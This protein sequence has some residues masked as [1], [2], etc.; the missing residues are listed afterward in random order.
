MRGVAIFYGQ[1]HFEFHWT[2]KYQAFRRRLEWLATYWKLE[3][4]SFLNFMSRLHRNLEPFQRDWGQFFSWY[5]CLKLD[6][7]RFLLNITTLTIYFLRTFLSFI[8]ND[9]SER[10]TIPQK[11]VDL[12]IR[13]YLPKYSNLTSSFFDDFLAYDNYSIAYYVNTGSLTWKKS[14]NKPKYLPTQLD[15]LFGKVLLLKCKGFCFQTNNETD[16]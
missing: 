2:P 1:R 9:V 6:I 5:C 14:C 16:L 12:A 11:T 3:L 8:F 4:H 7:W 15:S 10:T 13:T